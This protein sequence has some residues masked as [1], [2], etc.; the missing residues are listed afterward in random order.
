MDV[1]MAAQ[2]R[3]PPMPQ[4]RAMQVV[5]NSNACFAWEGCN[6]TIPGDPHTGSCNRTGVVTSDWRVCEA[7]CADAPRC[8][9]WT[10][11]GSPHVTSP[12]DPSIKG[13]GMCSWRS[14]CVWLG[15]NQ[16][17]RVSGFKGQAPPAPINTNPVAVPTSEQLEWMDLEVEILVLSSRI[18][19]CSSVCPIHVYRQSL[20][21]KVGAMIGF[22]LQTICVPHGHPNASSQRCQ[23]S[24]KS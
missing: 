18:V 4:T 12:T 13:N 3:C 16:R 1:W 7:L 14:D 22:N 5:N 10:W 15:V 8:R 17:N 23:A 11:G 6:N 19:A 2:Q 20:T 24:S 21:H 9:S